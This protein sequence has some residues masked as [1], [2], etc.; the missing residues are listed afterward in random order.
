MFHRDKNSLP[1]SEFKL[2]SVR[3]IFQVHVCLFS[4]RCNPL[5]LY[6]LQPRQRALVF[7]FSRFLDHTQRRATVGRTPLDVRAIR[8]R[9]LYLTTHNT[10]TDRHPCTRWDSNP[11]SQQASGRRPTPQTARPLGPAFQVLS[12][13]KSALLFK[14]QL[15]ETSIPKIHEDDIKVSRSVKIDL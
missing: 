12:T 14:S 13:R 7:S 8:R 15:S 1:Q 3:P 4:W 6:F 5:W 11:Q 9:D 10:Q 2:P